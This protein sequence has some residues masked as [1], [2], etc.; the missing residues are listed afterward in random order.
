MAR[1]RTVLAATLLPAILMSNA[2]QAA[3]VDPAK[4]ELEILKSEVA[5]ERA[6]LEAQR[7]RLQSLEDRLLS[8]VRGTASAEQIPAP[9][10]LATEAQPTAP[11][12]G[13]PV[14]IGI[15]P[16]ERERSPEVAVLSE[17]G[18]IVT[19]TGQITIEPSL[20]YAR[21][22]RN[23]VI[24]RGIEVP[25]SVLVGTFDINESRQDILTAALGIRFGINSRWEING[26]IPYVYRNDVSVLAAA[27]QNQNGSTADRSDNPARG[28]NIGDVEFGTRYQLTNGR[29]GFPYIIA[30]IQ[31]VAPTGTNPFTVPRDPGTG[32]ARRS[33]TGAGFWGVTPTLTA[34]LPSDPAVLFGTVGYTRNFGRDFDGVQIDQDLLIDHVKPGDAL[35]GSAGVGIS[36]NPRLALS[37]GYAHN[38][39]FGTRT[40]GRAIRRDP[41][42]G[43]TTTPFDT[44]LRDLQ[45]GRLLFGVSYRTSPSTTINWNVEVGAT[46]DAAD[47]R[48]SLRVPFSFGDRSN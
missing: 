29:R 7:Q 3:I 25:Q 47:V 4:S 43:T 30:G 32:V 16:P 46:N 39:S 18:G 37:F 17:Q 5:R 36:L 2:G 42:N 23:R 34:L 10:P 41:I 38:W 31:A 6:L 19:R 35:Q 44:K 40:E 8:R 15:A 1:R 22:D 24:F 12:A 26:R 27:V 13:A 9:S 11:A 48:T 20:E 14:Q 45:V 28:S 21:A 33:A